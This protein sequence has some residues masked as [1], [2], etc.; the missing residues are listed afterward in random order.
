MALGAYEVWEAIADI[1]EPDWP[2][3]TL[4]KIINIAFRDNYIRTEDHPVL[5]RLRGEL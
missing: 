1:P 4:Q 2:K 3:Y 5:K